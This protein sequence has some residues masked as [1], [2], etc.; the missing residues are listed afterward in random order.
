MRAERDRRAAIL[1]AEGTK[2]AAILT[3]EGG[4][5]AAVLT[6]EGARQAA[7]LR[8]EGE[9]EGDRDGL[10]GDPR[11]QP[12]SAVAQ[13]PVPADAAEARPGRGEQGLRDPVRVHPGIR[14]DRRLAEPPAA[15]KAR[16]RLNAGAGSG[17]GERGGLSCAHT[18]GPRR[19][20]LGR[21]APCPAPSQSSSRGVAVNSP[22]RRPDRPRGTIPSR[23]WCF[24]VRPELARRGP[25]LGRCSGRQRAS[26]S[27]RDPGPWSARADARR[28]ANEESS[29]A[30]SSLGA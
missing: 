27:P 17:V 20:S 29:G 5:Q 3:A 18:L 1:T 12:R 22:N 28:G 19:N 7:I 10:R 9:G 16:R 30:R 4:Q 14:R 15:A 23:G 6:A 26:C 13:L 2:Q 24:R 11:R 25:G 8:A 21:R